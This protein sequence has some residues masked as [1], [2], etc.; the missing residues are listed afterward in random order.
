[1]V[2]D[3]QPNDYQDVPYFFISDDAFAIRETMM[4]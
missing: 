1:M 3:P 4:I 2:P